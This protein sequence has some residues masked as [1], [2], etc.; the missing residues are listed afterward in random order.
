MAGLEPPAILPLEKFTAENHV[1]SQ[2]DAGTIFGNRARDNV[3]RIA[4]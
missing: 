4:F 1:G 3:S 2:I